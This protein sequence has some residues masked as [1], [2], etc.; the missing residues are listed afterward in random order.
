MSTIKATIVNSLSLTSCFHDLIM[1]STIL[2]TMN[3]HDTF[4]ARRLAEQ[5]TCN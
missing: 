1:S 5:Q 2:K 4:Q 3:Y